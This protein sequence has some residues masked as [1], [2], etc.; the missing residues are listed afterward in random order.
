M[1]TGKVRSGCPRSPERKRSTGAVGCRVGVGQILVAVG[2]NCAEVRG[3]VRVT[4]KVLRFA[5]AFGVVVA[6][7]DQRSTV[8]NINVAN[9]SAF[10]G[11]DDAELAM[12][13]T[14]SR[15]IASSAASRWR[16]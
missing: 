4:V 15:H 8:V 2:M 1:R 7:F 3:A 5:G 6:D 11:D 10:D 13:A 14:P 16:A 12:R 9:Q